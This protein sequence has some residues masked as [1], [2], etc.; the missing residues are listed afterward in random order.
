MMPPLAILTHE[1]RILS[2]SWLVRLWLVAAAV[3]TFVTIV[4]N[5]NQ[6]P[7]AT[8]IASVLFP[9]L[10]F[11]WFVVVFMLGIS[12]VTGSR[13]DALADGVLSRP[14]TRHEYLL[15]CWTARVLIVLGV[16]LSVTVPAVLIVTLAKRASAT[17]PVT[18]YGVIAS[19]VVV[20]LVLTMLV[21]LAFFAGT[22]L[23]K[24]LLAV[25]VLIFVWFP[26]NT[27][28]YTFSL[29]QFSP[30]SLDQALP[31][32]LRTPWS[33]A[34]E[35]AKGSVSAEDLRALR[36]ETSNFLSVLSGGT[37]QVE[38]PPPKFF[39][40]NDYRDFSLIRVLLGYGIPTLVTLLLTL[41]LFSR[42]DL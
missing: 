37:P 20:A 29:E 19:L 33:A 28:L 35:N 6:M 3:T 22:L 1:L 18:W 17:D 32:L 26:I 11:P 24:P 21:S 25:V 30:I 9:Y 13:L 8:L 31:T 36:R 38:A 23:R 34:N 39:E 27:V 41:I 7:T 16:Y 15:G 10:V 12:P 40:R 5:W 42:R 14:V 2:T 4:P